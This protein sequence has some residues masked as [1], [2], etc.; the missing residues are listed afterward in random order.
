MKRWGCSC[1]LTIRRLAARGAPHARSILARHLPEDRWTD[2]D[3]LTHMAE[4]ERWLFPE[5]PPVRRRILARHHAIF[6]VDIR[7]GRYNAKLWA[8]HAKLE[9]RW[10]AELPA[11]A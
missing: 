11:I 2:T 1:S 6:R 9:D 7:A 3:R 4:E 8:A 5:L 10:V